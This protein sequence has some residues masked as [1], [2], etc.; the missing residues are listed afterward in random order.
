MPSP[1][2]NSDLRNEDDDE[3]VQ[4][5][6]DR[7][8]S[9]HAGAAAETVRGELEKGLSEVGESRSEEWLQQNAD[10][11]STADPAQS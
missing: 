11:I 10:R 7:V 3:A 9:Y 8:L 6:V 5:V 2:Q 1:N 4:A